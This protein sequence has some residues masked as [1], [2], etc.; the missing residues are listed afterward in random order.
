MTR[1]EFQ[2]FYKKNKVAVIGV[3]VIIGILLLDMLVL[4][5]GRRKKT[6]GDQP[7]ATVAT[8]EQAPS[9]A[10]P[11]IDPL[12][13]PAPLN[14]PAL[15]LLRPEVARRFLAV[16]DYPHPATKNIFLPPIKAEAPLVVVTPGETPSVVPEV[17]IQRPDVTYHGFF[18]IGPDR[19]AILKR[20]GRLLLLRSGHGLPGSPFVLRAIESDRVVIT[21]TGNADREFEVTLTPDPNTPQR[22]TRGGQSSRMQTAFAGADGSLPAPRA[23]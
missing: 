8:A 5:P 17:V 18:V 21:D 1:E 7:A 3:P 11:G 15:P 22:D 14:V 13:P 20:N 12:A 4:K 6:E 2:E 10:A 19:V 23:E 9:A 16:E